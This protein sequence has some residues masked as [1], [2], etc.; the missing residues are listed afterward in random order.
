MPFLSHLDELRRRLT[1]VLVVVG[2]LTAAFY[3][4]ASDYFLNFILAPIK[5]WFPK[6]ATFVLLSPLAGATIRI[7]A[8]FYM[9]LIVGSP[10]IIWH[11]MRFFLPALKPNE[12]KYVIPTFIAMVLLFLG[13]VTFA[14]YVIFPPGFQWLIGQTPAG[15]T[16]T[17]QM[18]E[19]FDTAMLLLIGFG[20]GFQV[21]VVVFYLIIF[22]V[23][24]YATLRASWRYVY[25]IL[26]IISAVAT[27][28]WS[29]VTMGAMAAALV[30]LYEISLLF[31]RLVLNRRIKTAQAAG[32][33]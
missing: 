3:Y 25:V 10:V 7:K 20:L 15:A 30:V 27:P 24:P 22:R 1:I 33:E 17:P 21:P 26:L 13:G 18:M 19:F 29:P 32:L 5:P 6:G 23:I 4:P 8:A 9:A 31:A 14:Y 12:R 2:V 28:D 11:V 16:L